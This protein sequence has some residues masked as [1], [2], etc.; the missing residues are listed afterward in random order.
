MKENI[1][2]IYDGITLHVIKTERFKTNFLGMFILT[3]LNRDNVTKNALI[4]AVL[5][6]GTEKLATMK[7]ISIKLEDMY[8]AIFDASSDK[9]GD[10][11]AL[12]FYI[13]SLNDE[14][15]LDNSNLSLDCANLLCDIVLDPKIENGFFN[16]EYVKQEK[17]TLRE[18]INS[19]INDKNSYSL[20]RCIEEMYSGEPFGLYKWGYAQDLESISA[21]DLYNQYKEVLETSEIHIYI[22]GNIDELEMQNIFRDRFKFLNRRFNVF[23]INDKASIKKVNNKNIVEKQEVTQ[24]KLVLGYKLEN[25]NLVEDLYKMVLYSSILG[26]TPGSKLFQN[27]REKASLAYTVR[28]MYN[29]QKGILLVS[30]GIEID[31]YD[32]A[33]RLIKEQLE[34]LKNGDFSDDEINDAKVYISNAYRS[35]LDEQ[36]TI[37]DLYMGQKLLGISESIP[38]MIRKVNDVT[39]EEIID[40][41]NRLSLDVT[42][43]LTSNE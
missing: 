35:Y 9:I 15:T 16:E 5:R 8:G 29:R 1:I 19:K 38:D 31:K 40:V 4:P 3:E 26:G 20:N 14:Y 42:Y 2:E 32:E 36:S 18:L 22:S 10:R 23:S 34:S 21:I 43:F 28:S 33:L 39:R 27:V 6:R 25:V 41:A 7:E 24:G 17:E 13:T 12:Q 11:Q 37:I 30:A